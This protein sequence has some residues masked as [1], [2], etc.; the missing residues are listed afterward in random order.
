[1]NFFFFFEKKNAHIYMFMLSITYFVRVFFLQAKQIISPVKKQ[2][3][4][5]IHICREK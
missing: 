3:T 1:M 4:K 5:N 2:H